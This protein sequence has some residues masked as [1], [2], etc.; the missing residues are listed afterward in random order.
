MSGTSLDGVDIADV[1][2]TKDQIGWHFQLLNA[3]TY[4]IEKKILQLLSHAV[5]LSSEDLIHLSSKLGVFYGEMVNQFIK[6]Y[7]IDKTQISAVAAHGQT[8]FHQPQKGYTLQIGNG[9]EGAIKTGIKWI[10]DFRT[11]DVA[12]GGQG[13]PL[14]PMGDS[15]LFQ[16]LADSFLNLGGFANVSFPHKKN[17]VAY[18][19]CPANI[20]LN[21]LTKKLMNKSYDENG[22]LGK[23]GQIDKE[24][25]MRL[26]KIPYYHQDPPKSLGT[27]WLETAFNPVLTKVTNNDTLTTIYHHIAEQISRVLKAA[28]VQSVYV[29]G[30][31]AKNTF[32]IDL[33]RSKFY[34]G[35][36]IVPDLEIVDFKEAIVFAFLGVL[37][38]NNETNIL[39]SYTGARKDSSSGIIHNP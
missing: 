31:G 13:A 9:P 32:L 29:T 12:L 11:K 10:C 38:L 21:D 19:I 7:K 8:I 30:G 4:P 26:N 33:I 36:V 6:E 16:D 25:L 5:D 28:N 35:E 2:F 22:Q 15:L 37:R 27:E 23:K 14:V 24:L 39:A 20:V 1:V 17:I 34:V 3:E 18:D